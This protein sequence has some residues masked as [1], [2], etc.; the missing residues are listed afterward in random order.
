[1]AESNGSDRR[2]FSRIHTDQ[3]MSFSHVDARDQL[4]VSK[5]V[6]AGGIRFEAVGCEINMGDVI[7][8]TF[9]VGEQTITTVGR[10]VRATEIDPITLDIGLEFLEID[11]MDLRLLEDSTEQIPSI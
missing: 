3:V 2:K 7:R 4:G 1:M 6:S 5:D 11:A 9:N 10:V 8:V